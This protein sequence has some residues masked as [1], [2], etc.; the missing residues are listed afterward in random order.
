VQQ[1]FWADPPVARGVKVRSHH[2]Q[3]ASQAG[4]GAGSSAAITDPLPPFAATTER[5]TGTNAVFAAAEINDS[6]DFVRKSKV[7][8]IGISSLV[9]G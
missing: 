8:A 6:G 9:S 4:F 2:R 5:L 1:N 3:Q 7:F